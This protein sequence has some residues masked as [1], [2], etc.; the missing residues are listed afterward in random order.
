MRY[1][2]CARVRCRVQ[3]DE[4]LLGKEVY[5]TLLMRHHEPVVALL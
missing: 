5:D 3:G 2:R 1:F 4:L